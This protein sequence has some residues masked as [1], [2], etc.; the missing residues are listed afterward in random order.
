MGVPGRQPRWWFALVS[1]G[2]GLLAGTP[3]RARAEGLALTLQ[4]GYAVT[5]T[6]STDQAGSV[7]TADTATLQ[8]R[9][10][11]ALDQTIY[12]SLLFS[13]GASLDMT[14]G[15][16]K[17]DGVKTH[18]ED[19]VWNAFAR[20][21]W[22]NTLLG[23]G[24][25]FDRRWEEASS[26]TAGVTRSTPG[27]IREAYSTQ[28]AW[29][30]YELPSLDL[31]LARTDT[32]DT[33]R[34]ILDTTANEALL[35][36]RFD[37]TKTVGLRYSLRASDTEDRVRD[38]KTTSVDN[39]LA[40]SWGD[41]FLQGRGT[42][43][44]GYN[45]GTRAS[46]VTVG[47]NGSAQIFAQRLPAA[48]LSKIER[49]PD[50]PL[51]VALSINADL[52][53]GNASPQPPAGVNIG[54]SGDVITDR[55]YRDLGAR[56]ANAITPVNEIDVW[57]HRAIPAD[58]AA[59]GFTFTVYES[60]DNQTWT[61][62]PRSGAVEFDLF[63]PKFR[64]PIRRTGA[65]YLKVVVKPLTTALTNDPQYADLFVTEVQFFEVTQAAP[66]HTL[67]VGGSFNASARLQLVRAIGL[68]YDASAFVTHTNARGRV[69]W[70]VGNGLSAMQRYGRYWS[71]AE[72]VD[73]TDS[74]FG[75]GHEAS[76]RWSASAGADPI[77]A[78]GV[79][80]T[81]GGQYVQRPRG[82]IVAN[83][84]GGTVRADLYEGVA[85]AANATTSGSTGETGRFTRSVTSS[86]S[87]SL[88]PNRALT[89][90]GTVSYTTSE[91]TGGGLGPVN[92]KSGILEGAATFTPFPALALAGSVLRYFAGPQRST[93]LGFTGGFSPLPGGSLQLRYG[94]Q[95]TLDTGTET[96]TRNHGPG[97]RWNIRQG[98]FLEGGYAFQTT[99]SPTQHLEGQSANVNLFIALR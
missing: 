50:T 79:L 58:L 85:V 38:Y 15:E 31:R 87:L 33:H 10:R 43:Y 46:Q 92:T 77:P 71:L 39:S 13:S 23:G 74:D 12:P 99:T 27:A 59:T 20:L 54:T 9:Y 45:L 60:D 86:G 53:D 5:H 64:I 63:Q 96:R 78:F 95:E 51:N 90:S 21:R 42:G 61:V 4:P 69:T 40:A 62:V 35:S 19:Q 65:L 94:Y 25:D 83:S 2:L 88:V 98:W 81:Y 67:D 14:D 75:T 56:F 73:R 84:L 30:P 57:L 7:T 32:H 29:H 68:A 26:T 97:L 47:A 89:T 28:I 22:G 36:T 55:A 16:N 66:G 76:N 18:A 93:L 8:Q 3:A 91:A 80:V 48:G 1:A 52:V 49:F 34:T 11:L 24:L 41:T 37:P 82:N 72:R 17:V 6:R 44:A 70:S